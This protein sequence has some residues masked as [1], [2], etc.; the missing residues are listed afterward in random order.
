MEHSVPEGQ[1]QDHGCLDMRRHPEL[2][3]LYLRDAVRIVPNPWTYPGCRAFCRR[4]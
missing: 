2:I 3:A 4:A 1:G